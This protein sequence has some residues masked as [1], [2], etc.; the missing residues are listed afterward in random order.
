MRALLAVGLAMGSACA[1]IGCTCAEP[2]AVPHDG[3]DAAEARDAVAP[4]PDTLD[5]GDTSSADAMA[6]EDVALEEDVGCSCDVRPCQVV[7][8]V[9]ASCTYAPDTDGLD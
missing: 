3:G 8:C 5:A 9:S 4:M 2:S 7:L 1:S 6:A